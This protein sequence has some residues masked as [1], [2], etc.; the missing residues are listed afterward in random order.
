MINTPNGLHDQLSRCAELGMAME[1]ELRACSGL[2]EKE[3]EREFRSLQC[4]AIAAGWTADEIAAALWSLGH[5]SLN[6]KSA[7][8]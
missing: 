7:A 2:D 3:L 8:H 4:R 6:R 5:S 1:D